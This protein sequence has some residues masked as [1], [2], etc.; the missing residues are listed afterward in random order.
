MGRPYPVAAS[1]ALELV[2]VGPPRPATVIATTPHAI[3]LETADRDGAILCLASSAAI[4]VPCAL[5][6]ESKSLP[7]QVP[8]GTPA[9]VGGG[10]VTIRSSTGNPAFRVHRWWRPPRPRGLGTVPPAR[11]A[12]AVRWLVGRVADPLDPAGR[13]AVAELVTELAAGKAPDEP[14]A[15]LL[16]RGPGLTP[17]GD[18]VLAGALVTLHALGSPAAAPLAHAVRARASAATTTVSASPRSI[19]SAANPSA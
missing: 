19:M 6:L 4:R 8:P 14:V 16:G 5:I 11:L 13:S 10:H 17:T 7:P 3:Y 15:Q 18:D 9:E 2:L 1:A 12:T